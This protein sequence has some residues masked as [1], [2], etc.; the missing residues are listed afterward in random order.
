MLWDADNRLVMCNSKFMALHGLGL[1][2]VKAGLAYDT[3]AG[4]LTPPVVQN[5]LDDDG[6]SGGACSYEALLPDARWLQVN[7]RRTKDGGYVSV[8]TDITQLKRQEENLLDSE[9]RLTAMIADLKRSR[10]TLEL[11]A[12]QL[13]DLAERY[14]EQK[15]E[16][17]SANR[18]KS[19]FLAKMS[20]E[21]RTPLN[22][23]LGF[24]EIMEAGIFGALG[25]EKYTG[26]CRDIRRSGEYLLGL[27]ADILDMAEL[28][29][30]RVRMDRQTLVLDDVVDE[31]LAEVRT[32]AA[33]RNLNMEADALPGT[34]I[35]A[36]RRAMAKILHHLLSNAIKYTPEGGRVAVRARRVGEAVNLYVEDTGVGIPKDA[37]PKLARPFELVNL[38]AS[39]P[40]EGSGLGLAIARSLAELHGGGLRI[41]S[42]EGTG[43]IVLVHLPTRARTGFEIVQSALA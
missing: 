43:T 12:Q 1:D 40:S 41:R 38:D 16:A 30:G 22:A 13:A 24:S 23:I 18:A 4:R 20:H 34:T 37:L 36:D 3:V 25:S 9:R 29:A 32:L 27:I 8:G 26:Y 15:A 2:D 42:C 5:R 21:L 11:Q 31:A 14:L 28:E 33:S 19:E 7:E 6:A 17:E 35:H 10:Q 39:K